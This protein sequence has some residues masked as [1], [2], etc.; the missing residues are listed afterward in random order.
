MW[1]AG[2]LR[3]AGLEPT[4]HG[5]WERHEVLAGLRA[6]ARDRPPRTGD[7]RDT[8]GMPYPPA[9]AVQRTFGSMRAA[10]AE[11]GWPAG[12]TAVSDRQIL[13]ALRAYAQRHGHAPTV[14]TWR[15]E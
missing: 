2:A 13:D 15:R 3:A 12:W 9:T 4:V 14:S 11:L 10:Q 7:L 5:A 6:F 8:R 1:G